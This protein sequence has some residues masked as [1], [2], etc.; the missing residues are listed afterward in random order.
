MDGPGRGGMV[1]SL[2]SRFTRR[3]HETFNSGDESNGKLAELQAA[4]RQAP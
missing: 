1:K 4:I 3:F 2:T